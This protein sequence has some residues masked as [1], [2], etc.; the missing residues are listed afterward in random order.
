MF[1]DE[2]H[3]VSLLQLLPKHRSMEEASSST[4]SDCSGAHRRTRDVA[5]SPPSSNT[6][7]VRQCEVGQSKVLHCHRHVVREQRDT[8]VETLRISGS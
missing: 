5:S 6:E 3:V 1:C 7:L 2:T 4:C 8:I